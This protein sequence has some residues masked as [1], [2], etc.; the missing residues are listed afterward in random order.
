MDPRALQFVQ[1]HR[2]WKRLAKADQDELARWLQVHEL[3]DGATV[4]EQGAPGASLFIVLQGQASLQVRDRH[5][6]RH[7]VG[8]LG[9]GEPFGETEALEP[10]P[11]SQTV[12]AAGQL[13]LA[14]LT[15]SDLQLLERRSPKAASRL[16]AWLAAASGR[17]MR[18]LNRELDRLILQYA[19]FAPPP[20]EPSAWGRWWARLRGGQEER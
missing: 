8:T 9:P 14:E 20:A 12:V 13:V 3:A 15:V 11:R 4:V 5:G 18:A 19:A 16:L 7:V 10:A 6:D 2:E 1:Q 17:R